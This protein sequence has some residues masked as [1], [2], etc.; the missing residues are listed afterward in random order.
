MKR[1]FLFVFPV[2][3]LTG[4]SACIE[5]DP[6]MEVI[7]ENG[8]YC[9]EGDCDCPEG[10]TGVYCET[11]L[12]PKYLRAYELKVNSFPYYRDNGTNWDNGSTADVMGRLYVNGT[13]MTH[14]NTV[15]DAFWGVELEFNHKVRLNIDD[16]IKI[17]LYDMDSSTTGESMG[18]YTFVIR[19]WA[20]QRVEYVE[21]YNINSSHQIRM[22]L[23][24]KWIY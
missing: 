17:Q 5:T 14:T 3:F 11:A 10:Y 8:G 18:Y 20:E 15:E 13:P 1:I 2:L 22:E 6:C 16:E 23:H 21:L 7:C 19:P 24:G 12:I 9:D 4:F